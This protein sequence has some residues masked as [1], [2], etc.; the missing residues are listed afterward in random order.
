PGSLVFWGS[1]HYRR[2]QREQPLALQVPLLQLFPRY[3]EPHGMQIPQTGYLDIKHGGAKEPADALHR[4]RYVRTHR[5]QR[6]NREQDET[7]VL[8]GA[9][10]VTHVLFSTNPDHLGLYGKP[11][12]RNAQVWTHDFQ[13]LLDGPCHGR[14]QISAA[15]K[16][17]EEGGR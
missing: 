2:L 5:F 1:P 16:R 7:A 17:V 6:V 9:D 11:M 12:A 8:K 4:P 15:A 3:N 10:R 14:E 13:L